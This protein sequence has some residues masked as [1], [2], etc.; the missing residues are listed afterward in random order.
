MF[1]GF[2]FVFYQAACGFCIILAR[3]KNPRRPERWAAGWF[4]SGITNPLKQIT[5]PLKQITNPLKQITIPLEQNDY[6][7]SFCTRVMPLS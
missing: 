3:R 4:G 1:L 5:N 2:Y 6:R 7:M